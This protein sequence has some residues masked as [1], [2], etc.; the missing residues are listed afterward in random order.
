MTSLTFAVVLQA[1]VVA[2]GADSYAEA[3]RR[4]VQTGVPLVVLVGAEWCPAC[5]VLEN[6]VIPQVREHGY[7][8]CVAFAM[9]D[10]DREREISQRLVG[11]GPLPQMLMYRKT[12]EGWKVRKLV[13]SQPVHAVEWFIYQ[14]V[15]AD[16]QAKQAA[17]TQT[18]QTPQA[19]APSR[20]AATADA[21]QTARLSEKPS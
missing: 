17:A 1:S 7:L 5:K 8:R 10:Y 16:D 9:V 15:T 21:H 4:G 14:G 18:P 12:A 11:D 3:H 6:T 19:T 13:G 2:A 20:P